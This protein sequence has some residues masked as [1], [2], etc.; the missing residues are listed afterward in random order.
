MGQRDREWDCVIV[1][2]GPAGIFAALTFA[3]AGGLRV[4]LIERGPDLSERTRDRAHVLGGWGG[5]GAYSDGK[6]NLS[7]GIGGALT[8][9]VPQDEVERLIEHVD[10][11]FVRF[12]APDRLYEPDPAVVEET[13][14]RATRAGLRLLWT[15]IRHIGTDRCP[16]VLQGMRQALNDRIEVRTGAEVTGIVAEDGQVRGVQLASGEMLRAKHVIV[17]PGR[18]GA[19]WLVREARRLGLSLSRNPVDVGVRV[20][21]PEAILHDLT[22]QFYEVKLQFYSKTFDNLI[23]TFCMCPHGEVATEEHHGLVTVNGHTNPQRP[24]ANTNFAL[25]VSTTFT[26]PFDDPITYGRNLAQ[27]A[28]LLGAGVLVQR[29]TDLRAGRRSTPKRM[30]HGL[31]E[32]TLREA[33]PGDISYVLPYRHLSGILEMLDAMDQFAPG[34]ASRHTLLYA[35]EVKFYSSKPSLSPNLETRV[36]N[37]FA[38]GDGAGVSRGMVQAAASGIVAAR[39]VLR[40]Q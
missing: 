31:V 13:E 24:T 21:V 29:L 12:G 34:V 9:Y 6:L 5:A 19:E 22:E 2:A 4:A 39:E 7:T 26:E 18:S 8:A 1:G 15:R 20:E 10:E 40:R 32:P 30:C 37:L 11:T 23:R 14:R 28:N 17:A 27:L 25:L 33:T 36:R 3:E 35:V 16:H 38:A